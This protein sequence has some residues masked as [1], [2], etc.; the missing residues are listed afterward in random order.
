MS[1]QKHTQGR[2]TVTKSEIDSSRRNCHR[3]TTEIPATSQELEANA[4]LIEQAPNMLQTLQLVSIR[5]QM[6]REKLFDPGD[7]MMDA[8]IELNVAIEKATL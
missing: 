7:R 5:L 1:T 4:K 8:I 6:M 2:W 3:I